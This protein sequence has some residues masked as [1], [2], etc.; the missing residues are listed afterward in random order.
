MVVT[1]PKEPQ[2]DADG[3]LII[4]AVSPPHRAPIKRVLEYSL[5]VK[6]PVIARL[7]SAGCP[8]CVVGHNTPQI[9]HLTFFVLVAAHPSGRGRWWC[10]SGREGAAVGARESD[11]GDGGHQC[12]EP[13]RI[14]EQGRGGP[15]RQPNCVGRSEQ[16][17]RRRCE[18]NPLPSPMAIIARCYHPA[19]WRSS[20]IHCLM[21]RPVLQ[22]SIGS[23]Q[24]RHAA[25]TISP[26]DRS[27]T[28]V[29]LPSQPTQRCNLPASPPCLQ[30]RRRT[31]C[32][33]QCS[34]YCRAQGRAFAVPLPILCRESQCRA[35]GKLCVFVHR[36][37]RECAGEGAG[38]DRSSWPK[39]R[40]AP[41]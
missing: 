31:L 6:N 7:L 29:P 9:I 21:A 15:G 28:S 38:S 3:N 20:P 13:G 18:R 27:A 12:W 25:T 2:Y 40:C 1:K 8:P 4:T 34:A 35:H 22:G 37:W 16:W 32:R 5:S 19:G 39:F 24:W 26:P 41:L 23:A 30:V 14:P 33:A 36:R 10:R 17:L 11:G